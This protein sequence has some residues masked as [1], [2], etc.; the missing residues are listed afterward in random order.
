MVYLFVCAALLTYPTMTAAQEELV[1]KKALCTVCALNGGETEEEKVK[2]HSQHAGKAYYF[3][4]VDCKKQF[5]A[6]PVGFLPPVLPRPAPAVVVETLEGTDRSLGDFRGK[7]VLLD[8]WATWCKPCV[9]LMPQLQR[10]QDTYADKGLVVVGVSIDEGEDRVKK[11]EKFLRKVGVTYPIL[12][13]AKQ[14]PAWHQFK[15]KA[16]PAVFL[17]D[18][19]GQVVAQW[20]GKIEHQEIEGEIAG[21]FAAGTEKR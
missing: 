11:I 19:N 13:D 21:R 15:V 5:D 2:A 16:I 6:D 17:I 8:F 7:T 3:C 1:P 10:L 14:N 20:T 9:E 12:S 4:S 18:E